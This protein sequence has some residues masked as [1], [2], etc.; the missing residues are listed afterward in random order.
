M[1]RSWEEKAECVPLRLGQ[2]ANPVFSYSHTHCAGGTA[3]GRIRARSE[4]GTFE[5]WLEGEFSASI[6]ELA[7]AGVLASGAG[8]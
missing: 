3:K 2:T 1:R 4:P 7:G 8:R 6:V 5:A